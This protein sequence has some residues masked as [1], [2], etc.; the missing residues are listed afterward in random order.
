MQIS[1]ESESGFSV[2]RTYQVHSFVHVAMLA[3]ILVG[4]LLVRCLRAAG[5]SVL[6]LRTLVRILSKNVDDEQETYSQAMADR[7]IKVRLP[8][9]WWIMM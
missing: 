2:N 9:V 5:R 7:L 3:C 1:L 8:A 4:I 6:P